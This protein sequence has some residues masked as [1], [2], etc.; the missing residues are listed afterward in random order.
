[1][2]PFSGS[3]PVFICNDVDSDI[4]A[5]AIHDGHAVRADLL[6][7]LNLSAAE[8]LREEDPYTG[9]MAQ[10]CAA[11]MVGCRSRF[12]FDLN[13]PRERAVYR[14]P[15]DAWGLQVW[16]QPPSA[17]VVEASLAM[18]DEF[19]AALEKFLESRVRA[20][21]KVV[22]LDLHSYNHRRDGAAQRPADPAF[23]PEINLGT[24]S[25]DRAQWGVLVDRFMADLRGHDY[26][27]RRLDVREN[28]KFEG[29]NV[30]CWIYRRFPSTVCSLSI[31]FKKFFMDEWTGEADG[32]QVAA[33]TEML[34]ATL[35]GLRESLRAV[36]ASSGSVPARQDKAS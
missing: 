21:G 20:H 26:F 4:V 31:E 8:R 34:R 36:E 17:A 6:P 33:L 10:A 29:G 1:M 16:R 27:G 24:G 15:A 3:L 7:L 2:Q 35:P 11:W 13:R 22:V 28:V 23:N 14:Q 5:L 32:E 19:Y 18:Y 30:S 25:V 12:E 9:P